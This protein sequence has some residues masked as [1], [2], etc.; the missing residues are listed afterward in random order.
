[1]VLPDGGRIPLRDGDGLLYM[2]CVPVHDQRVALA[3]L[4][5]KHSI[6]KGAVILSSSTS[7]PSTATDKGD[8]GRVLGLQPQ[9]EVRTPPV[10]FWTFSVSSDKVRGNSGRL[11]DHPENL[12]TAFLDP[13]GTHVNFPHL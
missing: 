6:T 8:F 2:D 10:F 4:A 11:S 9:L 3:R 1:M 13:W 12:P 7:V 5:L